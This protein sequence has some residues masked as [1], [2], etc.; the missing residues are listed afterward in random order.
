HMENNRIG[1]GARPTRVAWSARYSRP[2]G[3][4]FGARGRYGSAPGCRGPRFAGAPRDGL[5]VP[6]PCCEAV[7]RRRGYV[8]RTGDRSGAAQEWAG[9]GTGLPPVGVRCQA[10]Q[11]TGGERPA[12]AKNR[13]ARGLPPSRAG[14]SPFRRRR[15]AMKER[16]NWGKITGQVL[17]I[18]IGGLM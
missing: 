14:S 17:H 16:N 15:R 1:R 6:R 7:Q 5:A 13:F 8:H 2:L 3:F 18:L 12:E 4:G 11:P 9:E 10:D